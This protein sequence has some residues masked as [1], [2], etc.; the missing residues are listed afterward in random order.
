M[1]MI[2]FS[3]ALFVSACAFTAAALL[4][5]QGAA[6]GFHVVYTFQSTTDGFESHAG[7]IKDS[8]GNLYG[9]TFYGGSTNLQQGTVFKL[10]PDGSKTTLYSFTGG[11]DGALPAELTM[12][13]AGNLYGTTLQG[14]R[15]GGCNSHGC[16]V[17]YKIATDGTETGLYTFSGASDGAFPQGALI[18]DRKG[19]LYG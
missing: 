10:A 3:R 14:G 8:A 4:P 18:F 15:I 13:A 19:N 5:Q 12:D 2:R 7:V 16:G 6:R 1:P 9:T 11:T 17:V